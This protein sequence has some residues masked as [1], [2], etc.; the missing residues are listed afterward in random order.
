MSLF[1]NLTNDGLEESQDRVG[2][3]RIYES[4]AYPGTI[5]MMYAGQSPKNPKAANIT[6]I[7][8]LDAGGTYSEEIYVTNK[9][10]ENFYVD[11]NDGKKKPLPGFTTIDDICQMTIGKGL[12]GAQ[13]EQKVVNIYDREQG[14][15]LPTSVQV[16]VEALGQKVTL[17]I[18]KQK[19][20]KMKRDGDNLVLN[21]T[22]DVNFIDKVFHVPSNLTVVEARNKIQQAKFY[23]VWVEA[24]KGKVK[25]KSTG[26][27]SNGGQNGRPGRPNTPPQANGAAPR[28]NSLFGNA[29][30]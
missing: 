25:D 9:N 24:N 4:D 6:V 16:C 10:G 14:K 26:G 19:E 22:R 2:G 21:G 30:N 29:G 11:K 12:A 20:D 23:G 7:L 27:A 8:D 5:K 28:T 13:F 1:G 18:I 17:G 15:E 3:F